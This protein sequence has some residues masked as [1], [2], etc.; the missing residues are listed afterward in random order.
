MSQRERNFQLT[1]WLLFLICAV[2]FIASAVRNGDRLYLVGSVVF[3]VACI[4]FLIPL[5]TK[6]RQTKP[7]SEHR[8]SGKNEA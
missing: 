1:G 5:V 2:F 4:A 3:F 8:D 6:G 7:A